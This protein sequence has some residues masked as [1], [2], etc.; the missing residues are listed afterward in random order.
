MRMYFHSFDLG[1]SY[2]YVRAKPKDLNSC[3][4]C[5]SESCDKCLVEIQNCLKT[6]TVNVK[7]FSF[8]QWDVYFTENT[9]DKDCSRQILLHTITAEVGQSI[10]MPGNNTSEHIDIMAKK[11]LAH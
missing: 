7:K 9:E 6:S 1:G 2:A 8:Y 5:N 10:V 3:K 4:E 11:N